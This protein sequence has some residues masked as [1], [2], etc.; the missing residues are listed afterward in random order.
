MD[1]NSLV[2]EAEHTPVKSTFEGPFPP[3]PPLTAPESQAAT[4]FEAEEQM[5][6]LEQT[7]GAG[8]E[9]QTTG[10]T[11]TKS[12]SDLP[13]QPIAGG[14]N[15][16]DSSVD[17]PQAMQKP[18]H[19]LPQAGTSSMDVDQNQSSPS[20]PP[21]LAPHTAGQPPLSRQDS[22][23]SLAVAP[24][25]SPLD[26]SSVSSAAAP[27]SEFLPAGISSGLPSS[28]SVKRLAEDDLQEDQGSNKRQRQSHSPALVSSQ[29]LQYGQSQ[30]IFHQA[31]ASLQSSNPMPSTDEVQ[32]KT[33][34]PQQSQ[35]QSDMQTDSPSVNLPTHDQPHA[36]TLPTASVPA[37]EDG[38]R[39]GSDAPSLAIANQE[40]AALPPSY[41]SSRQPSEP[42]T[43]MENA[44]QEQST[45]SEGGALNGTPDISASDT[46]AAFAEPVHTMAPNV[47]N[48]DYIPH[49]AA[50]PIV[51]AADGQQPQQQQPAATFHQGDTASQPAASSTLPVADGLSAG[52]ASQQA[53][54][55]ADGSAPPPAPVAGQPVPATP[56]PVRPPIQRSAIQIPNNQLK[57]CTTMLRQ[58]KKDKNAPPFMYP[59]DPV[60][61]GIPTYYAIITDP[62]DLSTVEKRLLSGAYSTANEFLEDLRKIFRNCY[63]FNGEQAPVSGMARQLEAL[64]SKLANKMP[65][66][67][68]SSSS[69]SFGR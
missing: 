43:A 3:S 27:P 31:D 36:G 54:P 55:P 23:N 20:L 14:M 12:T 26:L 19:T 42:V 68:M 22:T 39:S 9:P 21:G 11:F 59:V 6:S 49:H 40:S 30:E 46:T 7:E 56:A 57:Y 38:T 24:R 47:Q 61:L 51:S 50:A 15:S 66:E 37:F 63:R 58:L 25:A 52:D 48:V 16:I 10:E 32:S 53:I 65:A 1:L 64:F 69:A 41:T 34:Q 60:Y 35:S 45:A 4:S 13:F 44:P 8:A 18:A 33:V 17:T 62:M 29:P 28:S 5:G 2:N 67:V